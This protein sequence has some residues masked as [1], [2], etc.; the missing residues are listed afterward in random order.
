[1]SDSVCTGLVIGLDLLNSRR[2]R[3]AARTPKGRRMSKGRGQDSP[4]DRQG[5]QELRQWLDVW[6]ADARRP[7]PCSGPAG[8]RRAPG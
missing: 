4:L 8:G 7:P 2:G 1:M 3:L 6:Q 5:L